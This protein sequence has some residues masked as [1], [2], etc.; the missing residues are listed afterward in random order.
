MEPSPADLCLGCGAAV[1]AAAKF[2]GQCGR[3]LTGSGAAPAS[4]KWYH[5]VWFVLFMLF[6]VLGPMGLPLVWGNPRF[7][8]WAKWLLTLAMV[9]YTVALVDLTIRTVRTVVEHLNQNNAVFSF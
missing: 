1:S 5:N 8:R 4:S 3:A 9:V 7:A 2:C 6:F